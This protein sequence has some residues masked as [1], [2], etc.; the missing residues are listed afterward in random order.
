MMLQNSEKLLLSTEKNTNK[1]VEQ[2]KTTLLQ[3]LDFKVIEIL[4]TF[5]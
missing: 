3:I 5:C 4:E 2:T 1:L